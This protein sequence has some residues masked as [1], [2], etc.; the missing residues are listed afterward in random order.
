MEVVIEDLKD[1][2][3]W[4]DVELLEMREELEMLRAQNK[5]LKT[6]HLDEKMKRQTLE[7]NKQKYITLKE[8]QD[9]KGEIDNDTF[10]EN[11]RLHLKKT[12]GTFQKS[13]M[14][15]D[16]SNR[17]ANLAYKYGMHWLNVVRRRREERDRIYWVPN[18]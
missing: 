6:Q 15:Q 16:K 7:S 8:L 5:S 13:I 10:F 12:D 2:I 17:K 3:H 18:K 9:C 14:E 1:E 11:R 4:K